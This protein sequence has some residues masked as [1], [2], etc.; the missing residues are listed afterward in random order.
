MNTKFKNLV[1]SAAL[2]IVVGTCG[3]QAAGAV[4]VD[5][6]S[7]PMVS[8]VSK[9]VPPN[10]YF[11]LD[12]SS[13][14]NDEFMP[15]DVGTNSARNCYR[16]F[17]YN[18]IYYNPAVT[19]IAPKNADGT[20]FANS[21]YTAAKVDGFSSTSATVDL[22]KTVFALANNPFAVVNGSRTVTV[23]HSGHGRQ[24]P[25]YRFNLRID[26]P[27]DLGAEHSCGNPEISANVV[28]VDMGLEVLVDGRIRVV[29]IDDHKGNII[30]AGNLV[31]RFVFFR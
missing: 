18:K 11:I 19:Y 2:T 22:S 9:V 5:L 24:V 6:A 8:G 1:Q 10:V 20:S 17:G 28:G 4:T 26:Q 7:A 14:M 31:G 21:V 25:D 13:S 16:N 30:H 27:C 3:L 23:T 12:D 15:D 29:V